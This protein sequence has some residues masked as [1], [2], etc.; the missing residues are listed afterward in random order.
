MDEIELNQGIP[1]ANRPEALRFKA[2]VMPPEYF[3]TAYLM[4]L[5]PSIT[6]EIARDMVERNRSEQV[7]R[8]PAW[9]VHA[10]PVPGH[11][12]WPDMIHLNCRRVDRE[13]CH[14]WRELQLIKNCLVGPEHEAVEL[15]PAESRLTDTANN[16]HLWVLAKP[17]MRFPFGFADRAVLTTEEA[18][19][20]GAKQR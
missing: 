4:S 2:S 6:P 13:P 10:L 8:S 19:K 15:Y 20:F 12:N 14:D 9:Q 18:A 3:D 17:G 1:D 11:G 7:F 16:Y 5:D